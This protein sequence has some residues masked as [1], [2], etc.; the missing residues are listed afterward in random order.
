MKA[1]L[2]KYAALIREYE[3]T[4]WEIQPTSS[5]F[6]A[7]IVFIDGSCLLVK[8]YLFLRNGKSRKYAYHWQDHDG[9]LKV[10]WDNAAHWKQV[11]TFPHHKHER[12]EAHVVPSRE[13]SLEDVLQTIAQQIVV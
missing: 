5:R 6:K 9:H 3:I 13:V 8:E 11:S 7:K 12:D 4:T 1:M 10:R 2:D